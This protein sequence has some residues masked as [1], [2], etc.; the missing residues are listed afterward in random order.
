MRAAVA[1]WLRRAG[2]AL[3]DAVLPL[4]CLS[5]GAEVMAPGALCAACW[6]QLAFLGP[7]LCRRCGLPFD[8]AAAAGAGDDPVCGNCLAYPP[9]WDRARAAFLY[10]DLSRKLILAFKHGDQ[11]H[12]APAFGRMLQ[13]AAA[14]FLADVEVIAPVPLHRWRLLRRRYNQA[15]LL[16]L[17]LGR[18]AGRPVVPDL[19]VRRR[20]TPS[21]GGQDRR[22][23]RRNVAGAFAVRPGREALVEGRR[24]LLVDDVL[25]TG[26]T[27][28]ECARA[29]RRKGAAGVDVVTLARVP[30]PGS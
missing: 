26:A 15:A 11:T 22:A 19:L 13:R 7:P 14:P 12:A 17:A 23:R 8:H 6:A 1:P 21:Q 9:L 30:S 18:E 10:D 24:V 29:L 20:V 27:I 3:L 5:C 25:T 4:R 16:A 2:T 28:D